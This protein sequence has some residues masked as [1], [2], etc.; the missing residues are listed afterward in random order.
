MRIFV[1]ILL[2]V[3]FPLAVMAK[4]EAPQIPQEQDDPSSKK[5]EMCNPY[6]ELKMPETF[7]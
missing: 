3:S 1:L 7:Y 5:G 2:G 4:E 6:E